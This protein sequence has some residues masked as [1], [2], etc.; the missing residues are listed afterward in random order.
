M[1]RVEIAVV[2]G[3]V[4]AILLILWYFFGE[5][6][7]VVATE[8]ESGVQQVKITVR[9]GYSRDVV[10]V[11][12]GIPVRLDFYRDEASSC[13]DTVIFGDLGIAR[14]LPAFQTTAV[15]FTPN[16]AGEFNWTCGMGMLRGKLVVEPR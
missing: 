2:V 1:D 4:V 11:R 7:G 14:P 8:S 13:S 3:G 12:E 6:E 5:R 9:G 10:T 15:E 16:R